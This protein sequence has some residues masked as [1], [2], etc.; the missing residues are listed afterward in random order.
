MNRTDKNATRPQYD[1][2]PLPPLKAKPDASGHH[3]CPGDPEGNPCEKK[4]KTRSE[5]RYV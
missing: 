5:L 1:E 4:Y 2:R 3:Q